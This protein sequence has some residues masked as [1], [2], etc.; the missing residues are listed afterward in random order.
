MASIEKRTGRQGTHFRAKVRVK[1]HPEQTRT[2]ESKT[3]AREWARRVEVDL[4][5]G[6]DLPQRQHQNR[7]LGDLIERYRAEGLPAS[8]AGAYG[9]HL[10]WWA[11]RL[12][13]HRLAEIGAELV[14]GHRDRLAREPSR[15]GRKR[16]RSTVN[17]Y[18]NTLSAVFTFGQAEEVRWVEKNPVR[19]VR[20]YR[21]PR[22]R[23]R[24]LSRP[25]D[26]EGSELE[27]LLTAC[28]NSRNRD[29]HDLVVLGLLTGMRESEILG[30]R[31]SYVHLNEGGIT[32]PAEVT[33]NDETRFVPL[34]G[35]ALRIVARRMERNVDYLFAAVGR[36][37][38]PAGM[39][40]FPRRAWRTA[41][42][43]AG[44]PDFRFHDLRHTHGS[45]L[46]MTGATTREL[47]DA[48]GHRTTTMAARY[49]HLANAHKREVA[50][51]LLSIDGIG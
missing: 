38:A 41:L 28:R 18:L 11:E 5:R 32:L 31:R 13:S 21:E 12:G 14:A 50:E 37:N 10:A 35:D 8:C 24:F 51:R 34:V 19:S 22:G 23:Q 9:P 43:E 26:E 4:R 2:F 44:I 36:R 29:L 33:K 48:L 47:M 16:S 1:G 30:L 6:V 39:P 49:S 3:D 15:S 27:R 45:Y 7:T 17:R 20:R 46:A 40:L 25:V 42:R